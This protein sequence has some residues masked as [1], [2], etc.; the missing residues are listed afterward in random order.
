MDYLSNTNRSQI[1]TYIM[2]NQDIYIRVLDNIRDDGRNT[3]RR[4]NNQYIY[5]T[6]INSITHTENALVDRYFPQRNSYYSGFNPWVFT[7]RTTTTPRPNN[8]PVDV[9]TPLSP[10]FLNNFIYPTSSIDISANVT[11]SGWPNYESVPI[12]ASGE[13]IPIVSCPITHQE[14]EIG[15]SIARINR[16]GHVFSEQGLRRWLRTENSCPMCRSQV[17]SS[18]NIFDFTSQQNINH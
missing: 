7:P 9:E 11:F 13:P 15:D 5:R 10:S 17:D 8:T 16:C 18:Y 12:D 6:I 2:N 1:L 4:V 14:F 3:S